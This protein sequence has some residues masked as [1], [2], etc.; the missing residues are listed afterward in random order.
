MFERYFEA[1]LTRV[2]GA[3]FEEGCFSRESLRFDLYRG[4]VTLERLELRARA[5]D[6]LGL[7]LEL[8]GASL[9]RVEIAIPWATLGL[10][11]RGGGG[12][13]GARRRR[14]RRRRAAIAR[15][16]AS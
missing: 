11:A 14:A 3:Y 9:A 16:G 5:L 2:L 13:G 7:P 4:A 1:A 10:R 12:G 15:A 8:A 6:A